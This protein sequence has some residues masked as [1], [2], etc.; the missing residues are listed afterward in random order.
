MT[1]VED[2]KI[3]S[4]EL[5]VELDAAT[6]EMMT[7]IC[8]HQMTG[9]AWEEAVQRQHEAYEQWVAHLNDGAPART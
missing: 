2:F 4:H 1:T 7:L 6:S 3:K 5:L 8:V 9:A